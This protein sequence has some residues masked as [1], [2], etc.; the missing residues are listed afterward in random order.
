MTIS[1]LEEIECPCGYAFE[2]ELF[3]AISISDNPE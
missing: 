3:S 1:N 2:A